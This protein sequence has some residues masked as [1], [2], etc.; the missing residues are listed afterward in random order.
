MNA[1]DVLALIGDVA[2]AAAALFA[3]LALGKANDA[4]KEAK[5]QRIASEE[6]THEASQAAKDAAEERRAANA[7]A[8]A[9]RQEALEAAREASA[10]RLAAAK[11]AMSQQRWE[12]E[13]RLAER[14]ERVGE[15][16]EA[17]FWTAD[18]ERE[19]ERDPR[20]WW[21]L[22]NRLSQAMV[23]LRDRL[24]KC[25]ELVNQHLSGQAFGVASQARNEIEIELKY[26]R[27]ESER[28][29]S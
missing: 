21:P 3:F 20:S 10:D 7:E 1:G 6:A 5:A 29:P 17:I 11:F 25:A 19:L 23:G 8:K 9:A 26:L 2:A 22:R 27:H 28:P 4:I 13:Q 18:Q 16:V 15:I 14:I 12:Q 24:P